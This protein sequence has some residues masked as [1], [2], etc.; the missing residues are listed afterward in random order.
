MP[1]RWTGLMHMN[2]EKPT[3]FVLSSI[4]DDVHLDQQKRTRG[5]S[6]DECANRL[7]YHPGAFVEAHGELSCEDF[8]LSDAHMVKLGKEVTA[9]RSRLRVRARLAEKREEKDLPIDQQGKTRLA[10]RMESNFYAP[11]PEKSKTLTRRECVELVAP[12]SRKGLRKTRL[13]FEEKVQV[14]HKLYVR[15]EYQHVVA[16]ELSTTPAAICSIAKKYR[17]N[18]QWLVGLQRKREAK[19]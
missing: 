11:S 18:K 7:L 13:T 14:L 6:P 10:K 2:M 12:L 16:R 5:G 19:A 4:E 3:E 1:E 8:R 15:K 9:L 17:T